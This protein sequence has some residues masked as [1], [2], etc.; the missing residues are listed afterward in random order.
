MNRDPA[1]IAQAQAIVGRSLLIIDEENAPVISGT[2]YDAVT[3]NGWGYNPLDLHGQNA[4]TTKEV[5]LP[6]D[7]ENYRDI[8][9]ESTETTIIQN[10]HEVNVS[11]QYLFPGAYTLEEVVNKIGAELALW[12]LFVAK[13]NLN[14]IPFHLPI[15]TSIGIYPNLHDPQGRPAYYY[16]SRVPFKG[17]RNGV[18]PS[19]GS[20]ITLKDR[21]LDSVIAADIARTL[22]DQFGLTH[23]QLVMGNYFTHSGTKPFVA[24]LARITKP[25][26]RPS[27]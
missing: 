1:A 24:D 15:P 17:E 2:P 22:H 4:T 7:T 14:D 11:Q 16:T 8:H 9:P 5:F 18:I 23:N 27:L 26:F 25:V 10:G 3:I 13:G 6:S 19:K 20:T 12:K 21:I